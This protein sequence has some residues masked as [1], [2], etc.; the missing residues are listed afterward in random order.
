M[1]FLPL[2]FIYCASIFFDII[3]ENEHIFASFV[4]EALLA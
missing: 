1:M 2:A 3:G 4:E